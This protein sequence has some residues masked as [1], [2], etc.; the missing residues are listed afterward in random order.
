MPKQKDKP[1]LI[2]RF[3]VPPFS[4]LDARQ[5]YWQAR[6]RDWLALGIKSE[7]GRGADSETGGMLFRSA[8]SLPGFYEQKS[9][10]ERRL[11]RK[12][13]TMDFARHYFKARKSAVASG[14]SVFDPVLC[15]IA[16][17]WFCPIGGTVL[18]PFAGGSVRGLVAGMLGRRYVGIELR[19]EQITANQSQAVRLCPGVAPDWRRGDARQAG[20]VCWDVEADFL[21]SCPPYFDLER[22]SRDPADLSNMNWEDFC[23]AYTAVIAA[24][25]ARLREDRFACFVVSEIRNKRT[26]HYRDLVALTVRA[27]KAAG[28]ALY[29]DAVLVTQLGTL[30]IR[31]G[32]AFTGMRKLGR[33]HQNVLVFVKGDARRATAACGGE[34]I[35]LVDWL[36]QRTATGRIAA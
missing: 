15:E 8:T 32:R 1:S 24:N 2:D 25:C 18:D 28:L 13:R 5:G 22:Y 23:T 16:Y 11:G 6:K 20:K 35:A 36:K 7:S 27:F 30:P 12:L 34:H 9:A 21:F 29:N 3:I 31:A 14:N 17:T 4:V 10:T 33:G 19:R 26:G